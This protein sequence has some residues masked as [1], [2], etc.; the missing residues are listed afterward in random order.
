MSE[1]YGDERSFC[2]TICIDVANCR[3]VYWVNKIEP[4]PEIS[5]IAKELLKNGI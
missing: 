4:G 3:Q 1:F 2:E 5:E